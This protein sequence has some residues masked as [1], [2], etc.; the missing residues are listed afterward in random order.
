MFAAAITVRPPLAPRR[1]AAPARR[2]RDVCRAARGGRRGNRKPSVAAREID[3]HSR[4]RKIPRRSGIAGSPILCR[5]SG[6]GDGPDAGPRQGQWQRRWRHCQHRRSGIRPD[7]SVHWRL[8]RLGAASGSLRSLT[9]GSPVSCA[10][11]ARRSTA[12]SIISST[13]TPASGPGIAK[14]PTSTPHC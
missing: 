5:L 1:G 8:P 2:P 3:P 6:S 10:I 11:T 12:I 9:A 13:C 7:G 14:C 4:R